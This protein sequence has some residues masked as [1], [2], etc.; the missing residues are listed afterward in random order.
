MQ[1]CPRILDTTLT[2][3]D[4][5][6]VSKQRAIQDLFCAKFNFYEI[7]DLLVS[8]CCSQL[9]VVRVLVHSVPRENYQHH[10]D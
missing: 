6:G 2:D 8:L 4:I 10:L 3:K 5:P 9:V 7:P 1:K